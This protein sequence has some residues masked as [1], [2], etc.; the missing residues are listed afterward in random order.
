MQDIIAAVTQIGILPVI[1]LILL[2]DYSKKL[3]AMQVSLVLCDTKLTELQKTSDLMLNKLEK[4][5][6]RK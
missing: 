1:I 6:D 4:L 3:A 2:L 5:E